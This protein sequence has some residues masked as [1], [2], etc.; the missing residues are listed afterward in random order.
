MK[1]DSSYILV[2]SLDGEKMKC[3]IEIYVY[4]AIRIFWKLNIII[5]INVISYITA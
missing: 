5:F 2:A 4:K 3:R 1:N